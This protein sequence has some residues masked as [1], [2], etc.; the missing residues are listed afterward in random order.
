MFLVIRLIG[1]VLWL[2]APLQR[3]SR[4]YYHVDPA[5]EGG[6]MEFCGREPMDVLG[7]GDCSNN[8]EQFLAKK[9]WHTIQ[10]GVCLWNLARNYTSRSYCSKVFFCFGKPLGTSQPP[11]KTSCETPFFFGMIFPLGGE[12]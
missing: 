5:L 11:R 9:W 7:S 1:V 12:L 10:V 3:D 8:Y 6:D 4:Y 2:A